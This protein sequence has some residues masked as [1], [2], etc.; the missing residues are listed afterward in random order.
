M[1]PFDSMEEYVEYLSQKDIS[2]LEEIA[3]SIDRFTYP[4][5]YAAIQARLKKIRPV[6]NGE[7]TR[8][9]MSRSLKRGSFENLALTASLSQTMS[10]IYPFLILPLLGDGEVSVPV[11]IPIGLPL[12]LFLMLFTVY[13]RTSSFCRISAS[14]A[15]SRGQHL[16]IDG[17]RL[18]NS[19]VR[20]VVPID[21]AFVGSGRMYRPTLVVI[22]LMDAR[23]FVLFDYFSVIDI[24]TIGATKLFA[25]NQ[26][27]VVD[28]IKSGI[29][30]RK[31]RVS[32]LCGKCEDLWDILSPERH[33]DAQSAT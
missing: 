33:S 26:R 4:D 31:M 23:C 1:R 15:I 28:L 3:H 32:R 18:N 27:I 12:V 25:K 13:V 10:L 8:L 24:L 7:R 20:F 11:L 6:K 22:T 19:E 29:S 14:T 21:L 5:R 16:E 2:E 30:K 9:R 17:D